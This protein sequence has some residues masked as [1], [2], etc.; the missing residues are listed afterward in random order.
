MIVI[1]SHKPTVAGLSWEGDCI[2]E[3]NFIYNHIPNSNCKLGMQYKSKEVWVIATA[4]GNIAT[5]GGNIYRL[6]L[7]LAGDNL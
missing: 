3:I 7:S 1:Q 2:Y 5:A 6:T 4:G